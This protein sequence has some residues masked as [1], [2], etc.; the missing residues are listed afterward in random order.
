MAQLLST[1]TI[2]RFCITT[3]CRIANLMGS[4]IADPKEE[5]KKLS[6]EELAEAERRASVLLKQLLTAKEYFQLTQCGYLEVKSPSNPD[7][8]YRIPRR[9]SG[10]VKLY[11]RGKLEMFLCVQPVKSLPIDDVV[12]MHKLLIE[13]EEERYLKIANRWFLASRAWAPTPH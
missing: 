13:A 1:I 10:V 7:L 4:I 2:R 8:V 9:P 11:V 6:P 5:N 3:I 12:L